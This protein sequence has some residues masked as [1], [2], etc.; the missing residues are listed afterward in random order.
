MAP[1]CLDDAVHLSGDISRLS[2]ALFV[3]LRLGR[4]AGCESSLATIHATVA[5]RTSALSRSASSAD[6]LARSFAAER[7]TLVEQIRGIDFAELSRLLA[8]Q[9]A[10]TDWAAL[11][12]RAEPPPAFRLSQRGGGDQIAAKRPALAARRRLPRARSARFS[13]PADKA[14]GSV[15]RIPKGTFPD[16]AGFQSSAVSNYFRAAGRPWAAI[17]HTR[18]ALSDDQPGHARGN[19]RLSRRA[20]SLRSGGRRFANLLPGP[21]AG[22]RCG[23]RP[24]AVGRTGPRGPEPRWTRRNALGA[25]Q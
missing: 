1:T 25:G 11:A 18:A 5:R 9:E 16:R 14:R 6:V 13:S 23:D 17:W 22:R 12:R 8:G 19:R 2:L 7:E 4:T 10:A 20:Q 24:R 15:G 21:D 3:G